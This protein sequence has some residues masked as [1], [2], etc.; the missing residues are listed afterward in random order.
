MLKGSWLLV[1]L[2]LGF[3]VLHA[4][5]TA[6]SLLT[7]RY[8]NSVHTLMLD[9]VRSS[10]VWAF[11]LRVHYFWDRTSKFGEAW[12]VCSFLQMGGL[13][14]LIF[15]HLVYSGLVILPCFEDRVQSASGYNCIQASTSTVSTTEAPEFSINEE[16]Q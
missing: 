14:L 9:S 4:V 13:S 8:L 3:Q 2:T 6:S 15:G 16:R 10:T 11:G 1:C 5:Y 12:T 7:I